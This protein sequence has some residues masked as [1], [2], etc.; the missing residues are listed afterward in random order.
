MTTSLPT[1]ECTSDGQ[2]TA[3][4]HNLGTLDVVVTGFDA[5][6]ERVGVIVNPITE[7][8]AEVIDPGENAVRLVATLPDEDAELAEA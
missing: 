4:V 7:N 2:V 6:G 5:A 3:F 8:E 1:A